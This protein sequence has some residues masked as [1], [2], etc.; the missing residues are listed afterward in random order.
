MIL[1]MILETG[2]ISV[3]N[4]D[5]LI[6]L[7]GC[8][9]FKLLVAKLAKNVLRVE[10][11]RGESEGF[12]LFFVEVPNLRQP[13]WLYVGKLLLL[14][15]KPDSAYGPKSRVGFDLTT[16]IAYRAGSPLIQ[17]GCMTQT[18]RLEW[19]ELTIPMARQPILMFF[20]RVRWTTD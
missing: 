14:R 19:P 5:I 9:D 2:P 4:M 16:I 12:A 3:D 17:T 8:Q 7:S 10:Q 15:L 13:I 1:S 6:F 18:I 20:F 11:L